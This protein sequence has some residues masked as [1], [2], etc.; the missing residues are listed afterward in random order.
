MSISGATIWN[1]L[2]DKIKSINSH[3]AIKSKLTDH[4]ISKQLPQNTAQTKASISVYPQCI[5]KTKFFAKNSKSELIAN[6]IFFPAPFP[7]HI[8]LMCWSQISNFCHMPFLFHL[9]VIHRIAAPTTTISLFPLL[10]H[11][12]LPAPVIFTFSALSFRTSFLTYS[13]L[14]IGHTASLPLKLWK[15]TTQT[16]L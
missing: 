3:C 8:Q 5:P 12:Q 7:S 4:Y 2:P 9:Q 13:T 16:A 15:H 10:V 11:E 1:T 14:M 6:S